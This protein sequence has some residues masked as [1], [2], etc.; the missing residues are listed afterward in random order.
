MGTTRIKVIDLSSGEGEIKTSRKHA[1]KLSTSSKLKENKQEKT[2]EKQQFI[3]SDV[4]DVASQPP[5]EQSNDP[6]PEIQKELKED[7]IEP[8]PTKQKT[9]KSA[10]KRGANYQKAQSLIENKDYPLKE[11]L[12]LLPQTSFT[13]FDP[14][15]EVHLTVTEKNL[16]ATVVMPH[17]KSGNKTT[18]K[19]LIFGDKK[20]IKDQQIVWGDD[21]TVSEIEN[22]T[23]KAGKDFTAVAASPKYMPKLAKIAKILGPKGLMP[24][25]KSGTVTEDFEKLFTVSANNGITLKSDPSSP[26]IHTKIGKLS[27]KSDELQANFRALITTIGPSKIKKATITTSMGPAI[28]LDTTKLVA[29]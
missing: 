29:A 26:T 17:L 8:A 24:N 20:Q 13:K 18:T 16:K 3:P 4:Q 19:Y 21:K 5:E 22:G 27:Q 15:V 11:A 7:V 1:E 28:K 9:T 10:N 23:L 2:E 25:P 6:V 14:A 12:D